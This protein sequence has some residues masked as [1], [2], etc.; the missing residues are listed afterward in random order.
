MRIFAEAVLP[1]AKA[2][3]CAVSYLSVYTFLGLCLSKASAVKNES[4]LVLR[5]S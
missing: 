5:Q 2:F 3:D 4:D 1:R